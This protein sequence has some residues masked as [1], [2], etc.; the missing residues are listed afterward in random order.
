M[1]MHEQFIVICLSAE[2]F[3]VQASRR[4]WTDYEDA[5]AYAQTISPARMPIVVRGRWNE[6]KAA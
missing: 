5:R 6:L 1:A 3:Y 4:Y 2:G